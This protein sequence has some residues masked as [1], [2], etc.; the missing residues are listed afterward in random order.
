MK[1]GFFK[2]M[3]AAFAMVA[4][5]S[6]S[7]DLGLGNSAQNVGKADLTATLVDLDNSKYT[8][9]GMLETADG[10]NPW[11]NGAAAGWGWAFTE[12]DQIRVFSMESMTYELYNLTGGLDSPEGKFTKA[13]D[14]TVELP[15][16]RK[17]ALTEAQFV[18]SLS[19][20]DDGTPR[21]TYTIPYR[22]YAKTNATTTEKNGETIEANVQ[23]FPVPFWAEAKEGEETADGVTLDASLIPLTA[24]L[25]IDMAELPDN[26][27][28]IVLTTHGRVTGVNTP[29]GVDPWSIEEEGFQ[30]VQPDPN[31][32]Y[33]TDP[34]TQ[35]KING[36]LVRYQ[37]TQGWWLNHE[38]ETS[39]TDGNSE[40]LSGTFNARLEIADEVVIDPAW[41]VADNDKRDPRGWK[42]PALGVDQG[43]E[44][45]DTFYDTYG[46]SRLVTRD[47]IVI[48][49]TKYD[50][51][52]VFW[53]PIIAKQHF[54]NLHVLAVTEFGARPYSYV[55]NELA[56]FSNY[57][58]MPGERKALTLNMQNV[59]EVCPW[60]LNKAIESIN[61]KNQSGMT[62]DNVLNVDLLDACSHA[63]HECGY[64]ALAG[65]Y[66][67]G[68]GPFNLNYSRGDARRYTAFETSR[69]I[70]TDKV[71][72]QGEGNL[73]L[74]I[75]KITTITDVKFGENG[76]AV[77]TDIDTQIETEPVTGLLVSDQF[78]DDLSKSYKNVGTVSGN[79]VTVNVP[80]T[81]AQD[82]YILMSD[83][84]NYDVT[85]AANQDYAPA[86]AEDLVV[87]AHGAPTNFVTGN[88]VLQVETDAD[89]KQSVTLK[90]F[91]TAA[92][93]VVS[94]IKTLNVLP[95]T[96]GDVYVYP[97]MATDVEI[98]EA[99]NVYTQTG[100]DVRIDNALVYDLNYQKS[101][102]NHQNWVY[103]T[104]SAAMHHVGVIDD[105][106]YAEVPNDVSLMS[107]WTGS[108]LNV[109]Q[110]NIEKYDVK[111]I[112]T[113]AQLASMGEGISAGADGQA[114]TGDAQAEYIIDN[115]V[116]GMWLGG[117]KYG[118]V[119]A[120]VTVDGFTFDG[121]G[122]ALKNMYMPSAT[123]ANTSNINPRE[124]Y[125]MDPHFCCT[126]CGWNIGTGKYVSDQETTGKNLQLTSW[127]LIRSIDN[128]DATTI[129]NVY[130]NDVYA[131]QDGV[132]NIGSVVGIASNDASITFSNNIV[133]EVEI[134]LSGDNVGGMVGS[135]ASPTVTI[136]NSKV[137]SDSK[138]INGGDNVGGLIGYAASDEDNELNKITITNSEVELSDGIT[139][140]TYAGGMIGYA[141]AED[142]RGNIILLSNNS[143]K[144]TNDITADVYS[145]GVAGYLEDYNIR[146]EDQNVDAKNIKAVG[147]PAADD[148]DD[149]NGN[150][151]AGFVGML[152]TTN[153][154][155]IENADVDVTG[156][157]SAN[158]Q[159]AGGLVGYGDNPT[160]R[161]YSNDVA[162]GTISAEN[163]YVGGEL[164]YTP[165]GKVYVG[166][167]DPVEENVKEI[168]NITVGKLAGA[169]A[170]GG[171]VGNNANNAEI[172]VTASPKNGL[173][174]GTTKYG[175]FINVAIDAFENTKG[176]TKEEL[177]AY[178]T[179]EGADSKAQLAGT[180]SNILGMI[181]GKL[182]I[183]EANL[184]VTD[185]LQSE[186][187]I[188]VG[189]QQRPDQLGTPG[190]DVRK[191][192]G[193][194]NGY[195]GAGKS[196]MYYLTD[197][198][199][200]ISS[201]L[202]KVVGDQPNAKTGYNLYKTDDK[203]SATSKL[204]TE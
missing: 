163:G 154:A 31:G 72:A 52:G 23:Q 177:D 22:Y 5:A 164:A 165:Q 58:F 4:L 28:Y 9:M 71:R 76:S 73:I 20:M 130:L 115:L 132:D 125:I 173:A 43:L 53:V 56:N 189:Y 137:A 17:W 169:Y 67:H 152:K 123:S 197:T 8:R 196:G 106:D 172:W 69:T 194:Y 97:G 101:S 16:G 60:E 42:Y 185:N 138:K 195:V 10:Q 160:L 99:L 51:N 147:E 88:N 98:N 40:A 36:D 105:P 198:Q 18:Y 158:N 38:Y 82:S 162:A 204:V 116:E 50:N 2:L 179:P 118:W 144:V 30:L 61:H 119:G 141:K 37:N 59:G 90:D 45:G 35:V 190:T 120:E 27:K 11:S 65:Y 15:D 89:G 176:S 182:Y 117:A 32:D 126:T 100:I 203:Y 25:R 83:L 128:A 193:D 155:R 66:W 74:N 109:D 192:W 21:L 133:G 175:T 199:S 62:A 19:P 156:E 55:G 92:I 77:R 142:E 103:T 127:G 135:I 136:E 166:K 68:Y 81:S 79:K 150:Y 78:V 188:A 12:G 1:K 149:V 143:V 85:I 14:Q 112:Y 84:T 47:E 134:D 75:A 107:F 33:S 3:T 26:A 181:D 94:G 7:D 48:D 151:A 70:P 39:I 161:L 44:E 111:T 29:N 186:M 122:K 201:D 191:F 184:S 64:N 200:A 131:D 86:E 153:I 139:A 49:L 180:M 167:K 91:K 157:I 93:T 168:T 121:N 96:K 178:F 57:T 170:V 159:F 113:T 145:G 202:S 34:V 110:E 80:A 108:A 63:G 114:T 46:I 171:I 6:C 41:A 87:Y 95:E 124:I 148:D 24:F 129:K 183:N 187:K 102:N 54:N 146:I 140:D 13:P 104:G 174:K